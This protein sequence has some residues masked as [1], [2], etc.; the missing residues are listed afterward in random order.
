MATST[1]WEP[2]LC[3]TLVLFI[4]HLMKAPAPIPSPDTCKA[5]LQEEAGKPL[6]FFRQVFEPQL[7]HTASRPG[8]WL[9]VSLCNFASVTLRNTNGGK[10]VSKLVIYIWASG[11][12]L[13]SPL[14][15]GPQIKKTKSSICH[16]GSHDSLVGM[17][18]N[19][20]FL[21]AQHL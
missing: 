16:L 20:Q 18:P 17:K 5:G 13:S 7:I 15:R 2:T 11:T 10:E 14:K 3:I 4:I 12:D 19:E 8:F 9:Y 21:H 1:S 6:P